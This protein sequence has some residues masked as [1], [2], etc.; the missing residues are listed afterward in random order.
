MQASS[1]SNLP[2]QFSLELLQAINDWQR[3]G[4]HKQKQ[5]RGKKLKE[6]AADLSPEFREES[7]NCYRQITLDKKYV[8]KLADKLKLEE[9]ISAWTV[10]LDIAKGIKGEVPHKENQLQ[11][12]IFHIIPTSGSVV[13]NLDKLFNDPVFLEAC[14]THKSQINSYHLGIGQYGQSQREVVIELDQLPINNS[15]ALGGHSSSKEKLLILWAGIEF[16]RLPTAADRVEFE[17]RISKSGAQLG[18]NW[19]SGESKD[20]VLNNLLI[21]FERLKPGKETGT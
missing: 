19:I 1:V 14:D 20:R 4:D 11:V 2:K 12:A 16:N 10:D 6:L 8:W 9:T 3:G 5:R 21:D 17:K 7:R 15:Y 13:I 18:P